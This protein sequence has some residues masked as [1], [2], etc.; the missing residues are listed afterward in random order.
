MTPAQLHAA[1]ERLDNMAPAEASETDELVTEI[2]HE[3]SALVRAYTQRE[4][5]EVKRLASDLREM[6]EGLSAEVSGME[7]DPS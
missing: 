5:A 3:V 7:A 2:E 6:L 4:V 1:Q